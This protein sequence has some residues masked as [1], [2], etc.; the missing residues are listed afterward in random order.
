MLLYVAYMFTPVHVCLLF[1]GIKLELEGVYMGIVRKQK[2]LLKFCENLFS[3]ISFTFLSFWYLF[4]HSL[5]IMYLFSYFFFCCL[6]IYVS[7]LTFFRLFMC[8]FVSVSSLFLS[9]L[10]WV[11]VF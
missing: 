8:T 2:L 9:F 3:V 6:I 7:F 11:T 5:F 4:R 10:V 1:I